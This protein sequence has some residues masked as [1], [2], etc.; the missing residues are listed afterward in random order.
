M[1]Y[2]CG[3]GVLADGAS[4]RLQ[5]VVQARGMLKDL[6]GVRACVCIAR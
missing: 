2:A 6:C 5:R 1:L 3:V 4:T